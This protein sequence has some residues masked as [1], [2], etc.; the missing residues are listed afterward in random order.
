MRGEADVEVTSGGN[1]LAFSL[2][3]TGGVCE[4]RCGLADGSLAVNQAPRSRTN[5]P[6]QTDPGEVFSTFTK[7]PQFNGYG[8][9]AC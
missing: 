9:R 5:S 4:W 8:S 2:E 6:A 1:D 7:K 3:F